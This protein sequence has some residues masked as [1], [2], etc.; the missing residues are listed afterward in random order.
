MNK[1][2]LQVYDVDNCT[3]CEDQIY[4]TDVEYIKTELLSIDSTDVYEFLQRKSYQ[5][6]RGEQGH[7]L[8]YDLDIPKIINDYIKE[9]INEK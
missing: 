4:D 1:I 3:W 6:E 7:A 5:T 2:Y 8:Y 9:L